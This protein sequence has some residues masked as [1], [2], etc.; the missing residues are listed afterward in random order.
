[1]LASAMDIE[2]QR[3]QVLLEDRV[4]I[5]A[6]EPPRIAKLEECNSANRASFLIQ[7]GELF[8]RLSQLKLFGQRTS[9]RRGWCFG[10]WAK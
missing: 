3:F 8:G 10:S 5:R 6:T 7:L 1:M 9:D 4:I 2:E